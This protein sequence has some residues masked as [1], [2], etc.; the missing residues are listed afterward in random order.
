MELPFLPLGAAEALFGGGAVL[1]VY[2]CGVQSFKICTVMVRRVDGKKVAGAPADSLDGVFTAFQHQQCPSAGYPDGDILGVRLMADGDK[3]SLAV[4]DYG[5]RTVFSVS[6]GS[7]LAVLFQTGMGRVELNRL[8]SEQCVLLL[9][10][11][12]DASV[13]ADD[14]QC[15]LPAADRDDC[16]VLVVR[17]ATDS[18]V[19]YGPAQL[20]LT[21]GMGQGGWTAPLDGTFVLLPAA[22]V[23]IMRPRRLFLTEGSE[24]DGDDIYC[25]FAGCMRERMQVWFECADTFDNSLNDDGLLEVEF[26]VLNEA[27]TVVMTAVDCVPVTLPNR[28]LRFDVAIQAGSWPDGKYSVQVYFLGRALM[29]TD[30][31]L[32][33]CIFGAGAVH[34]LC[35]ALTSP[36][37]QPEALTVEQALAPIQA[38]VG[39]SDV[40]RQLNKDL[41]RTRLNR[42]REKAGLRTHKRSC[43]II[44]TGNPGTGKTTVARHWGAALKAM[45]LL[46]KGEV[47]ECDRAALTEDHIGGTE[48]RTSELIERAQGNVLFIDEAYSLYC[49]KDSRDYGRR[50]IET[51]MTKLSEVDSD[52]VVIFAGYP[53]EMEQL[54]ESNPGLKSRFPVN[55]CFPDYTVT[56]LIEI[57]ERWFDSYDYRLSDAA[58]HKLQAVISGVMQLCPANFGNGRFIDNLCDC[59]IEP[60]VAVRV[61]DR[62]DAAGVGDP[63]LTDI[64]PE[65]IPE[66]AEVV[67]ALGLQAQVQHRVGFHQ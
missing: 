25:G 51:L 30:F 12:G 5:Q 65:D 55:L 27:G 37:V 10:G 46:S 9:S 38:M 62:L 53:K 64:L 3:P 67:S 50:V 42:K 35:E 52:M 66:V 23:S 20:S 40:K 54:I 24:A 47:V 41:K 32:G 49:D 56:E 17:I 15:L 61:D 22:G 18:W 43:H 31:E 36:V 60:N 29:S 14:I 57:A 4:S 13:I 45:G 59:L 28:R 58:R 16:Y 44:M 26:R 33:R 19:Q 39:L 6:E 7:F 63:L 2:L 48:K 11:A 21:L 8:Y 34:D 1:S